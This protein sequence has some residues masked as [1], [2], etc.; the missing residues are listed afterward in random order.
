MNDASMITRAQ[1]EVDLKDA[2]RARDERRKLTLRGILAAVQRAEV[3]GGG[4][5][6][7]AGLTAVLQREAKARREAIADAQK[8]HRPE[9]AAS[10][11][12]ELV[13]IESYLPRMLSEEELVRLVQ[14]ALAESGA[15]DLQ[16]LGAVMKILGPQVKGR[17]D[18]RVVSDLVRQ[19]LSRTPPDGS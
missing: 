3:E 11:Q 13:I 15:A 1:L 5:L 16:Q 8:A 17:A 10:E 14:E 18:G 19:Q 2:L 4:P 7:E 12:A 9:F 6:G